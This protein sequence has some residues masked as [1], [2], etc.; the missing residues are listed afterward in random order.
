[1]LPQPLLE[2]PPP[3]LGAPQ[4][5]ETLWPDPRSRPS[6]RFLRK[7]TAQRVVPFV[8][9]GRLVFFDPLAVR[10]ALDRQ[11]KVESR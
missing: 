8:K 6:L 1:M 7:L 5:L 3:L 4:L 10:A 2:A 11:F 9:L